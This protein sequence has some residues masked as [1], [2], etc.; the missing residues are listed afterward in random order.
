MSVNMSLTCEGCKVHLWIA[1][2]GVSG[3]MLYYGVP[4]LMH[5]LRDMLFEH[6]G[7]HLSFVSNG[8]WEDGQYTDLAPDI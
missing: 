4:A 8:E 1:Q 2:Q 6:Q 3:S 5:A 7:H